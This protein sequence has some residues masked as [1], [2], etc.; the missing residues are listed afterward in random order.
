MGTGGSR[1]CETHCPRM[2]WLWPG[3]GIAAA[4][5]DN[6]LADLRE[7]GENGLDGDEKSDRSSIG[8][9]LRLPSS[10]RIPPSKLVSPPLATQIQVWPV[11]GGRKSLKSNRRGML[12]HNGPGSMNSVR[13]FPRSCDYTFLTLCRSSRVHPCILQQPFPHQRAHANVPWRGV[14]AGRAQPNRSHLLGVP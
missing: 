9:N 2:G 10:C 8:H 11:V 14:D 6:V 13:E 12:T 7:T 3:V 4:I 5:V 1:G